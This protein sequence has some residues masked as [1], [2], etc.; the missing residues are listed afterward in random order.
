MKKRVFLVLLAIGM[1]LSISNTVFA[2]TTELNVGSEAITEENAENDTNIE[3]L[4]EQEIYNQNFQLL[5]AQLQLA[6]QEQ[7]RQTM[8]GTMTII[9]EMNDEQRLLVEYIEKAR[10]LKE[11][12]VSNNE[13]QSMMEN[14]M[15]D[16]L[17]ENNILY[18]DDGDDMWFSV[19][20]WE[21]QIDIL[22]SFMV[23]Q[24]REMQDSIKT[25][26]SY[27]GQIDSYVG[28]TN[29]QK[30]NTNQ[31]LASLARGQSMYG[32]SEVGLAMTGLV[33]G[34]VL[35]CVITLL[36]QKTK[37]KKEKA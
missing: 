2:T 23:D 8:N 24:N 31:T 37:R 5:C 26:Q 20:E 22:E 34:F 13:G 11:E 30:N 1:L 14:D 3:Q 21:K 18:D 27:I 25:L 7:E 4:D 29:E 9:A 17:K 6:L 10:V 35:G 32:D 16:Y 36:L 19:E 28:E 12:A 15:Y 33:V